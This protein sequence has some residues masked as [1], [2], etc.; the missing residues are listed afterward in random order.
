[1]GTLATY[2]DK[3]GQKIRD[4]NY[5]QFTKA[6]RL[7][8]VN[9]ILETIY[10]S[11]VNVESNLVYAEDTITTVASTAEYTP[12]FS[13]DGFLQEGSWV[14][15]EDEYLTQLSEAD[16]I[17]Y[18]YGTTTSQPE[19]FYVTED[20]K[21]GYLW[22]PDAAYTIHHQYWKP[23]TAL[24]DYDTDTLPWGGI[25]N[26]AIERLLTIEMM[27]IL[28]LDNSR[29]SMLADIEMDK[30]L[31]MVYNRGIRR[32]KVMSNMFSIEGI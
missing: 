23:L 4:T 8:M 14:D 27:E 11:L 19:A 6:I 32:R 20:G 24:T 7:E 12:S 16:K 31:T 5:K 28:D 30:A 15:G 9:D 22:I 2:A 13:F 3:A 25:F 18:D 29:H 1:M 10:Q 26:R 21:I 17:K